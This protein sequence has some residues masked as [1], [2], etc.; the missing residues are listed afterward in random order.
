MAQ[1]TLPVLSVRDLN[2]LYEGFSDEDDE[3][4]KPVFLYSSFGY[5][6]SDYTAYFGQSALRKYDLRLEDIRDS[7]K[8]LLDEEVYPQAPSNLTIIPIEDE[9]KLFIKGPRLNTAFIGTKELPKLLLQEAKTLQFLAHHPH[10][11]IVRYHGCLIRRGLIVGLGLERCEVTMEEQLRAGLQD[12]DVDTFMRQI[13]SAVKH[14]HSIGL[15]H[16]DINPTNIMFNK[17]QPILIDFGSC[18]PFGCTLITTG[19]PGW[20]DDDFTLSAPQHDET[21]LGKI[22]IWLEENVNSM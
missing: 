6:T 21:A 15:A 4:G 5:V 7:L 14:L 16:N 8:L 11:N 3:H 20:T 9:G 1:K 22:R 12:F 2:P 10:P 19:T 17:Q 13:T 18:Q